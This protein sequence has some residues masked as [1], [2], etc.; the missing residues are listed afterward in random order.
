VAVSTYRVGDNIMIEG[1]G[2]GPL[3]SSNRF[4]IDISYFICTSPM[5]EYGRVLYEAI[6][7]N[8]L[9]IVSDGSEKMETGPQHGFLL[10]RNCFALL[11]IF[12]DN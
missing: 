8:R 10:R 4:D 1:M 5:E 3:L 11:T 12:K 9:L 2:S 7:T 6:F